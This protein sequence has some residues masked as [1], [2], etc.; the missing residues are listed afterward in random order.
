MASQRRERDTDHDE[1]LVHNRREE[2]ERAEKAILDAAK[3]HRF[4]ERSMF[5]L[6][7]ALEEA[8]MNAFKH[9][10]RSIPDEPVELR[11]TIDDA[12]AEIVVQD[13]GPGFNPG[14]V[15]D[16]TSDDRLELP[17][18]RGLMLMQAYMSSIEF[19]EQGNRVTMVHEPGRASEG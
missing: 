2:I 19:N 8:V 18:G 11:W 13:R 12:R 3:R 7:L 5:A 14:G 10:H 1:V 16:P 17:T 4:P 15:P 9:G 6:R